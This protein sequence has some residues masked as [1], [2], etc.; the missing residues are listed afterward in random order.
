ML[1]APAITILP[2]TRGL[3]RQPQ[4]VDKAG[5]WP[6]RRTRDPDLASLAEHP[7]GGALA[8]AVGRLVTFLQ[9]DP[10]TRPDPAGFLLFAE[11]QS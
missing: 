11:A 10:A 4:A 7:D 3:V 1:P 5:A 6:E 9:F 8:L 2:F